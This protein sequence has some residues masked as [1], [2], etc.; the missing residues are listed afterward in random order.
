MPIINALFEGLTKMH[1]VTLEPLAGLATH[2]ESNPDRTRFTFYLRGHPSPR[3][4]RLPNSDTLREEYRA[5]KLTEDLSRG[6][7]APSDALPARWSD[8]VVITTHDF[9]Y[10]WRRVVDPKVASPNAASLYDIRNAEEI[11]RGRAPADALGVRA[12]DDF[13]LQVDLRTPTP[14]FLQLQS[15]RMFRAVP[16]HV[17]EQAAARGPGDLVD[18][19]RT[20]GDERSIHPARVAP[21]PTNWWSSEI[22]A[23]TNRRWWDLTK[24]C[25]FRL[26]VPL[27]LNLYKAGMAHALALGWFPS[28]IGVRH[29]AGKRDLQ[30]SPY[31]I[32]M[33]TSSIRGSGPLTT[34]FCGMPSVW[35]P[36]ETRWRGPFSAGMRLSLVI[37]S[38][39]QATSPDSQPA[40][41][42]SGQNLRRTGPRPERRPRVAPAAAGFPGGIGPDGRRLSIEILTMVELPFDEVLQNQWR[43]VLGVD[44]RIEQQEFKVWIQSLINVT[45]DGVAAGGWTANTSTELVH[46]LLRERL[47]SEW[48]WMS[49]PT[50]DAMLAEA[51]ATVDSHE[52]LRKLADCERF[53][54]K[55]MPMLGIYAASSPFL[56]KPYVRGIPFNPL[57]ENLFEYGWIDTRWRQPES[58][59]SSAR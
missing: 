13:T 5:G 41:N 32:G 50:F 31:W 12:L 48:D 57:S 10:A 9:V 11:N 56:Q 28:V 1:P 51:N 58:R 44:V 53:L 20:H 45:Y 33:I 52:R 30:S 24:L 16:R 4:I 18:G 37:S 54:L 14:F 34:F 46:R 8:G 29:F 42:R 27:G 23:T 3:G 6:R 40:S 59:P 21:V 26:A 36:I 15:Q 19:A 35:R 39:R 43:S 49:D 7:V 17:I 55:V 38:R 47:R 2:Y 22:P 25:F